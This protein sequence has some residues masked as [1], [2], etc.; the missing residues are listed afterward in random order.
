MNIHSFID[1]ITNSSTELFVGES[2][3][4]IDTVKEILS[5]ILAGYDTAL[6][7]DNVFGEIK[8]LTE[9]DAEEVLDTVTDFCGGDLFF[10]GIPSAPVYHPYGSNV[11]W[12][13]ANKIHE[14]DMK[15]W[16]DKYFK[17][18]TQNVVGK[19]WVIGDGDNSVP[20]DVWEQIEDIFDMSGDRLHLG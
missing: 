17:R 11:S 16:K 6:S 1:V 5:E 9:D 4:A 19:L 7:V 10:D 12:E 13:E 3:K 20:Y 8:L 14:A 2:T 18:F 15:E